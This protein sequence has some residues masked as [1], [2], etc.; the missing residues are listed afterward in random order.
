MHTVKGGGFACFQ[1]LVL[2][3]VC[4]ARFINLFNRA[5]KKV[6]YLQLEI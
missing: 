1:H 4:Y 6:N 5:F 3:S 2:W